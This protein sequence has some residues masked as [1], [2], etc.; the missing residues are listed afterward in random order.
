MKLIRDAVKSDYPDYKIVNITTA[1]FPIFKK[2][3][4]CLATLQKGL[5]VVMDF[6]L[7]LLNLGLDI[8][9][10]SNLLSIDEVLINNAFYDLEQ[11]N[12]Y[13]IKQG[14]LTDDGRKYISTNKYEYLQRVELPVTVDSYSGR[15]NKAKNFISNKS[16]KFLNLNTLEPILDK[17]NNGSI[18]GRAIKQILKEYISENNLDYE[19]E[20]VEIV[21]VIDKPTE[22]KQMY[23][24][25][26]EDLD[27][28]CK[29]VVYDRNTKVD[30][31]ESQLNIADE[32]GINFFTDKT[33]DLFLNKV[34]E[35]E[36][37]NII[38][39]E[40]DEEIYSVLDSKFFNT[41]YNHIYF[42]IPMIEAYKINDEWI[43]DLERYLKRD[44]SVKIR[45][46]GPKYSTT[47]IKNRVFDIIAL[48]Q[49]YKNLELEHNINYEY[50]KVIF[51]KNSGYVDKI[52]KYNLPLINNPSCTTHKFF[53]INKVDSKLF[54]PRNTNS[55]IKLIS[56]N[57]EL[58]KVAKNIR[59]AS[60]SL[61]IEME[62]Y[63]GVGWLDNGEFLNEYNFNSFKLINNAKNFGDFTKKLNASMVEVIEKVGNEMQIN[64]YY[65]NDFQTNYPALF[66]AL[67]RLKVYRNSMQHNDLDS[68]NLEKY[69]KYIEIDLNGSFPEFHPNGYQILQSI[70]LNE[71]Y[72]AIL[73]TSEMLK[74]EMV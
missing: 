71:I 61:D 24:V 17:Q 15:V 35:N 51:D 7:K 2:T 4:V 13:D 44:L 14:R 32:I 53:K 59:D 63:F 28:K 30:Y 47:Y 42:D 73:N 27:G 64:N 10:I 72:T 38:E 12:M 67:D 50:A 16:A 57:N 62:D 69:L 26:I 41:D 1:G 21:K 55:T 58:E 68:N 34:N 45:F 18:H 46:N 40:P 36:H 52:T 74:R 48:S 66:Y 70:I 25:V 31:L 8:S 54:E 29:L 43:R 33:I 5:P 23:I 49:K 20:L 9:Q 3:V 39:N 11:N 6:T 19:G 65:Y 56:N 22:Y 37:L 60:K